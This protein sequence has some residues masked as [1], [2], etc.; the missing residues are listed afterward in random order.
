MLKEVLR[1]GGKMVKIKAERYYALPWFNMVELIA[2]QPH[3]S[4]SSA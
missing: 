2:P 4:V 1:Y 3:N